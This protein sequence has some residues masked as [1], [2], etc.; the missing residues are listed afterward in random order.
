MNEMHITGAF[1]LKLS[2]FVTAEISADYV[3]GHP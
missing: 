1:V 2:I 3:W